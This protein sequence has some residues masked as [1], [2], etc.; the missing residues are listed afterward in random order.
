MA[1]YFNGKLIGSSYGE[2]TKLNSSSNKNIKDVKQQQPKSLIIQNVDPK[3]G[4]TISYQ[5]RSG[6]SARTYSTQA[7]AEQVAAQES[8]TPQV[9]NAPVAP[10]N[11]VIGGKVVSQSPQFNPNFY[12]QQNG[13]SVNIQTY[14]Q[15]LNRDAASGKL[16]QAEYNQRLLVLN[17]QAQKSLNLSN[18]IYGQSQKSLIANQFQPDFLTA[19]KIEQKPTFIPPI[20]TK[21]EKGYA[22]SKLESTQTQPT[23]KVSENKSILDQ[24]LGTSF[25]KTEQLTDIKTGKQY[26]ESRFTPGVFYGSETKTAGFGL[27]GFTVQDKNLVELTPQQY[28]LV[29]VSARKQ[30]SIELGSSII[31]SPILKGTMAAGS[32]LFPGLEREV[33]KLLKPKIV[34]GSEKVFLKQGTLVNDLK[35]SVVGKGT[36]TFKETTGLKEKLFKFTDWKRFAPK[37]K[38]IALDF[39]FNV[40]QGMNVV[41]PVKIQAIGTLPEG[42]QLIVAK[43]LNLEFKVPKELVGKPFTLSN[44]NEDALQQLASKRLG[45]VGE[46]RGVQKFKYEGFISVGSDTKVIGG[47]QLAYGKG[48]PKVRVSPKSLIFS[49]DQEIPS[50]TKLSS[51]VKLFDETGLVTGKVSS[52]VEERLGSFAGNYKQVLKVGEVPVNVKGVLMKGKPANVFDVGKVK[53]LQPTNKSLIYNL[54]KNINPDLAYKLDKSLTN[55]KSNLVKANVK[56]G[57]PIS[58]MIDRGIYNTTSRPDIKVSNS[59][60]EL[61]KMYIADA[62]TV[63]AIVPNELK[64]VSLSS[65]KSSIAPQVVSTAKSVYGQTIAVKPLLSSDVKAIIAASTRVGVGLETEYLIKPNSVFSPTNQVN[66]SKLNTNVVPSF[67][68][69]SITSPRI[70]QG[71]S[72]KQNQVDIQSVSQGT[73]GIQS[74]GFKSSQ[75]DIQVPSTSIKQTE[76]QGIKQNNQQQLKQRQIQQTMQKQVTS[77]RYLPKINFK[78]PKIPVFIPPVVFPSVKNLVSGKK[79]KNFKLKGAFSVV[80]RVKG[81][82]VTLALGVPRNLAVAI[83]KKFTG[84]TTARSF[85]IQQVGFTQKAD[86]GNQNLLQYRSPKIGGRVSREGFTFVEKSR[87]AIDTP[88]EVRGLRE[89]KITQK[90][91]YDKFLLPKL[92]F[93]VLSNTSKKELNALKKFKGRLS[94]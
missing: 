46:L 70:A 40:E 15:Q 49:A 84:E 6:G 86:I 2:K 39:G 24:A 74:S 42:N 75:I 47:S 50:L 9:T 36:Y 89:G 80:S 65:V 87:F 7:E 92:K 26:S 93:D 20:T 51:K 67:G 60:R 81:K 56:I 59:L 52:V 58:K 5:T 44:L 29:N 88:G 4:K 19:A 11:I 55:F 71:I 17:Q 69:I 16:S 43:K 48:L 54:G 21:Q 45:S 32:S 30:S 91:K 62:K 8:I 85:K 27:K 13:K 57:E 66:V 25:F 79:K 73:K 1:I 10:G 31:T 53:V 64:Q 72:S 82:K 28:D 14:A 12:F 76:I 3:T 63:S 23:L 22:P 18:Q 35:S 34:V 68:Q 38:Q 83:G 33:G 61:Q 77:L 90:S 94:N 41:K 78:T 37:E